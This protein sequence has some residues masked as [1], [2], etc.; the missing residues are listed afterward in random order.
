M[1]LFII[2]KEMFASLI[3]ASGN[4]QNIYIFTI[5]LLLSL[6]AEIHCNVASLFTT[7]FPIIAVNVI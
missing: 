4:Q 7:A 6:L 2:F 3:F 5:L 1:Q